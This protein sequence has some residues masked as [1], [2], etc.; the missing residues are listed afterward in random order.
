W[1]DLFNGKDTTGWTHAKADEPNRWT[2]EDG[3]LTQEGPKGT[4]DTATTA[5]YGDYELELEYKVPPDGNSGVYLRGWVEVQVLDSHPNRDKKPGQGD[6][7]AIYGAGAPLKISSKPA[8]EWNKFRIVHIGPRITVYHNGVLVQDN[9]HKAD[10]TPGNMKAAR[11]ELDG[12]KGPL[13]LQGD[14]GKV[15][16]KNIRIRPLLEGWK[17][18]WNGTDLSELTARGNDRAK[19]GLRWSVENHSFTNGDNF[20]SKGHDIW[21]KEPFGNFLVH[22]EY[23][24]GP[25]EGGNSGFYL[26]DQWEIQIYGTS[27][28]GGI[29]DDGDLYSRFDTLT[30]A[31][32]EPS[33]WNHMDVKVDGMKIWVWQNGKLIHDGRIVDTRTDD[34]ARKT[35]E[36]SKA[37]FKLQGDHGRVWFTNLFVKPLPDTK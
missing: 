17:K 16:F 5:T 6:A 32:N 35:L 21:T 2:V 37:P 10:G 11:R 4:H 1:V 36:W 22:Y 31:R 3:A 26:R 24:T 34:H 23:R 7:G 15:W 20:G 9:V 33:Q 30:V 14:H 28:A 13:M 19:D 12:T 18:L 25:E 27:T 29:H 8:G